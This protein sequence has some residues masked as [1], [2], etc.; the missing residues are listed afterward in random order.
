MNLKEFMSGFE[1][2]KEEDYSPVPEG[3][4]E[5]VVDSV[6]IENRDVIN[7]ENNQTKSASLAKVCFKIVGPTHANRL[8]W[9]NCWLTHPN[10]KAN[11][12][13][14][15]KMHKLANCIGISPTNSS[16]EDYCGKK[17]QITVTINGKYNNVDR[18]EALLESPPV[19]EPSPVE[20][21]D[22]EAG[23]DPW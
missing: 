7:K 15:S 3:K 10:P 17:C 22:A 1:P 4:Y 6:K 18:Y 12:T 11:T 21:D 14:K 13:G 16:Q 5:A 23:V 9:D 19:A 2:P 8:I 20:D